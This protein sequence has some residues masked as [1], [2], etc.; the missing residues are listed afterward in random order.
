VPSPLTIGRYTLL[1]ELGQGATGIVYKAHDPQL[2]RVVAIKR[3]HASLEGG[4]APSEDRRRRFAQEAMAAGRLNHP[5]IVAVHD[6][7]EIAGVA[8]LVMEYVD[9]RTLAELIGTEAPLTPDRAVQ[10]LRP[11][12]WA[13]EYAH[14]RGV[15]HRDIKPG[16]ILVADSGDVKLGD[17]GIARLVG[18]TATQTGAMLG[19][20]AYMSPEQ[21]RGW[22]TDGRS[23]L[24]SLGVVLYEAL[25]GVTP[26]P[27][28]DL[29]TILYQIAHTDPAPVAARN[30]AVSPAL[31]AALARA[32]GKDPEKRYA[33]GAA[34]ADALAEALCPPS[35]AARPSR[36]RLRPRGRRA[37]TP[38]A[39]AVGSACLLALGV[40]SW[41]L[42]SR[43]TPHERGEIRPEPNRRASTAPPAESPAPPAM[44]L[45]QAVTIAAPPPDVAGEAATNIAALGRGTIRIATNPS[46]DVWLDGRYQGRT[47]AQP[48]VIADVRAGE[49][50]IRLRHGA[51]EHALRRTLHAGVPLLLSHYFPEGPDPESGATTP[52]GSATSGGR[53][54]PPPSPVAAMCLSVN[55]VPFA[56]VFV[57]G[58]DAGETP[59]A[60]L[61]VSV[62]EH[63]VHFE[64]SGV[65]SPERIVQVTDEHTARNAV[66]LSYDFDARRF[67]E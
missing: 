47:S 30:P 53:A 59:K 18:H 67:V 7:V 42:G 55:A 36:H 4:G 1:G 11:V 46:V 15:V 23:D 24:F 45:G 41:G 32:L 3:L 13:L 9:G 19:S 14:A 8:Y 43:V 40:G 52:S 38:R 29:A 26:F 25:A 39:V 31:D 34:L 27:G 49:R 16:N 51:Q 66:R 5:N 54:D 64:A 6:L 58:H 61:R 60:C 22:A 65:R 35:L 63:R 33:T 37:A 50:Q 62:G 20:P 2:D 17:F 12:C 56:Q 10:L 57:D 48:L 28:D 21:I 44:E